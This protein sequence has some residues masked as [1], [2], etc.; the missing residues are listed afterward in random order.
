MVLRTALRFLVFDKPK[1]IG[2]LLGIVISV[3][4]IGQQSGIF[5]FLT[6]AMSRLV[7]I[8]T[9]PIWVVDSRTTN[10]NAMVPIDAR[11]TREIF[12][13][14]DVLNTY[15]MVIA[16][17][18]AKL[19][20]GKTA[21]MTLI[22]TQAPNFI[23]GPWNIISGNK[24][25][26]VSE[27]GITTD[28]YD[29]KALSNVSVGSVFEV[30]GKKVRIVAQ[31][32][33]ARGFGAVYGFTT[34]E[35]ARSL[36]KVSL[37]K[38]SAILVTLKPNANVDSVVKSINSRIFGVRAWKKEEFSAATKKTILGSSG[39][40][41]STGTLIVFAVISGLIIIGLTL[42]SAAIDRIKDYATMKAIGAT[43]GYI[44]NLILSQALIL[45]FIGYL[46]GSVLLEFFRIGIGKSGAVFEYTLLIRAIFLGLTLFIS[47]CG[48]IFAIRRINGVEPATVFRG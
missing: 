35:R 47:L 36:G 33:G 25:D 4:L 9:V 17:G 46:I 22:G 42:Y 7:D 19:P 28:F 20:D 2:A 34:I 48:A 24:S 6:N 40:A 43:N 37:D 12:S 45:A 26:I 15:P 39:I 8:S 13:L 11:L 30:S 1:S 21:G 23:G 44:R 29:A 14:P 10:V 18:S 32:K 5:L 41:I 38:V 27:G 16:S 31:T 3:F